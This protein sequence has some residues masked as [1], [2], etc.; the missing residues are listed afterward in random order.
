MAIITKVLIIVALACMVN[1][2][3]LGEQEQEAQANLLSVDEVPQQDASAIS[4]A[5]VRQKRHGFGYGGKCCRLKRF[6]KHR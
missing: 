3:P 4:D 6:N 2:L 1:A 5:S